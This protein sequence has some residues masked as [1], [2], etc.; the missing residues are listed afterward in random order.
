MLHNLRG[1][2]QLRYLWREQSGLCPVCGQKITKLMGWHNHHLVYRVMG[3]SDSAE[4][5]VLLHPEC[6]RSVHSRKLFVEKPRPA[7]GI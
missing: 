4:N 6:H 3:G 5:R 1:I 7:R 2:R